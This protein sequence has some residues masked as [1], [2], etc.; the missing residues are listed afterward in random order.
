M[1]A[2]SPDEL[3]T[4]DPGRQYPVDLLW[5]GGIGT[6]IKAANQTNAAGRAG[7][8]A[9]DAVRVNG[10]QLR[11]RVIGEGGNLGLTQGGRIG[12]PAAQAA[13]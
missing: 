4:G 12:V 2:L 7:D 1:T 3:I 5:N 6:Y 10:G 8:R 13:W 11:A 9:N